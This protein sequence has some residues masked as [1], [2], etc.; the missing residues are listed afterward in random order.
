MQVELVDT[1][2]ECIQFMGL[3]NL[4]VPHDIAGASTIE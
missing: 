2:A 1:L 3:I 4:A